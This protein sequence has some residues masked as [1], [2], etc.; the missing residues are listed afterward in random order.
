MCAMSEISQP[1]LIGDA[2]RIVSHET[3][4]RVRSAEL[5][6]RG[7]MAFKVL[8]QTDGQARYIVRFYPPGRESVVDCEPD[9]WSRFRREGV[10]V[11]VVLA[12]SRTGPRAQLAY[13]AY[14]MIEGEM[15]SDALIRRDAAGREMLAGSLVESLRRLGSLEFEGSGELVTSRRATH[16]SWQAFVRNSIEAGK[17][18]LRRYSLVNGEIADLLDV[19]LDSVPVP[20]WSATPRFVWGDIAF[21]NIL[22]DPQGRIAGFIDFESC[23]S[24][25]P[26]ATLGYC[27][28]MHGDH[29]FCATLLD[30]WPGIDHEGRDRICF[31]A[32]LRALRLAPYAHKPLP[33]GRPRD[34]LT[35]IYPGLLPALSALQRRLASRQTASQ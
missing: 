17:L 14:H 25:D 10:P 4:T 11:P 12:D 5:I 15:L 31:Y 35:A 23:M 9:L 32:I 2:K 7:L 16:Q 34:A 33:T 27:L 3:G 29:S 8:V 6:Q 13:V 30:T 22:V 28:A 18:A 19:V 20:D 24:G 1:A 21:D 26:L